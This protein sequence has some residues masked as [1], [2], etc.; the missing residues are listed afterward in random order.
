MKK[1]TSILLLV[2]L[3]F[4]LFGYHLVFYFQVENAKAEMMASLKNQKGHRD[5]IQLSFTESDVKQLVWEDEKEFRFNGEMYD[6]VEKEQKSGQLVIHCIP[7]KKETTLIK[8]YQKNN[9]HNRSDSI[10]ELVNAQFVLPSEYS[11][12]PLQRN[13]T[14]TYFERSYS[15]LSRAS[16]IFIPPPEVC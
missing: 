12:K 7:D 3:S 5:V 9:K 10:V 6:V 11:V 16:F 15:L 2:C 8:E 14:K 4:I 13:I 1:L